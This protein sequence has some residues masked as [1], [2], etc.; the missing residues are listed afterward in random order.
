MNKNSERGLTGD[1]HQV[2]SDIAD[3]LYHVS[4]AITQGG[5]GEG[6]KLFLM[7]HSMGGAESLVYLLSQPQSFATAQALKQGALLPFSGLLVESP[8]IAFP[9]GSQPSS[10][11]VFAGRIAGKMLPHMQMV[12]K[13][14]ASNMS[15]DPKVCEEWKNDPLC[16]DTGTLQGLAGLLDRAGHLDAVGGGSKAGGKEC[17]GLMGRLPCPVFWAHGTGDKVCDFAASKKLY[18]RLAA[19]GGKDAW[20][21]ENLFRAYEGA[22]HK[23][24]AEP[25][26]VGEEFA[27]DVGGWILRV[28]KVGQ[29]RMQSEIA[30]GHGPL[31]EVANGKHTTES[32]GGGAEGVKSRL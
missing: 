28:A 19:D 30:T 23:L 20:H 8:H 17:G 7:G 22:Y 12:Q 24:H 11:L 3:F 10:L 31:Q 21:S 1:T 15:R 29:G 32:M 25:D 18:D 14:E 13:L 4:S 26:G 2:E 27:K 5:G 9:S 16:H 6:A